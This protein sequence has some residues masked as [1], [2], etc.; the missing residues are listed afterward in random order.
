MCIQTKLVHRWHHC[1]RPSHHPKEVKAL[2]S[3]CK[4]TNLHLN[5]C[6]TK[7]MVSDLRKVQRT[8][9][10]LHQWDTCGETQQPQ[11]PQGPYQQGNEV[12]NP[13]W[14]VRTANQCLFFLTEERRKR[15]KR[16]ST[17]KKILCNFYRCT[18]WSVL[19]GCIVAWFGSSSKQDWKALQR[20]THHADHPSHR[21]FTSPSSGTHYRSI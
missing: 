21:L 14:V 19:S 15:L 7:E 3:W 11:V 10:C 6:R 2:T 9:S 1:T 5:V 4:D 12:D 20:T 16:F 8:Q 17:K 18:M 13:Y